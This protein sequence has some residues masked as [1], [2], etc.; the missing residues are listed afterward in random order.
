MWMFSKPP[1]PGLPSGS[2]AFCCRNKRRWTIYFVSLCFQ[3]W[4]SPIPLRRISG[5]SVDV[6]EGAIVLFGVGVIFFLM[7]RQTE[8]LEKATRLVANIIP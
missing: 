6:L 1:L 7:L 5:G 2:K 4:S 3:E 8:G